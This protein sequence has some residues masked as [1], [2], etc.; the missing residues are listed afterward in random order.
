MLA[1]AKDIALFERVDDKDLM[2]GFIDST[3][4]ALWL[5]GFPT[6]RNYISRPGHHTRHTECLPYRK[7][8]RLGR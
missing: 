3:C 8:R 2:D 5:V 4:S 6:R 7:D 1:L